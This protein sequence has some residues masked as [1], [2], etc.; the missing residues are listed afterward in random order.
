MTDFHIKIE[1]AQGN[2]VSASEIRR[3]NEEIDR[4][5]AIDGEKT[6]A[7]FAQ[8]FFYEDGSHA[9]VGK[10]FSGEAF[11]YLKEQLK[12]A[13]EMQNARQASD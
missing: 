8:L 3:V 5:A 10:I 12:I 9:I 13:S 7:T 4:I 1:P 11:A 6:M 2:A